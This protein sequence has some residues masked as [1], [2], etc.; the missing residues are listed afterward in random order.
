M[1]KSVKMIE[2]YIYLFHTQ[3]FLVLPTYPESIQ[4]F[5]SAN[6]SSVTPLSRSAPVYSY[7][8][9]GPRS[10][11]IT[12]ALH[13]DLMYDLNYGVSNFNMTEQSKTIGEIDNKLSDDYVDILV[14][15]IQAIALPRYEAATK[16]VDPPMVAIRFGNEIFIK[17]VVQGSVSITYSGPILSNNKYAEVQISF[18]VQEVDPYDATTVQKS[19]SMRGLSSTLERRIYRK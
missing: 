8:N 14:R 3:E 5:L 12:L 2:N 1:E 16:M 7:V 13:R 15:R 10:M 18:Q 6:F 4:D 9:S 11:Q 17:G 19:G